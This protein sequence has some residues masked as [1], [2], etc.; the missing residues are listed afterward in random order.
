MTWHYSS[1]KWRH[2]HVA[3]NWCY[4]TNCTWRDF[5]ARWDNNCNKEKHIAKL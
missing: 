3:L 5:Y 4:Q 2:C 1:Y